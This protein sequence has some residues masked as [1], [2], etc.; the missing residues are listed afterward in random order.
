MSL[1]RFD[2]SSIPPQANINEA[3]LRIYPYE[4]DAAVEMTVE[5]YRLLRPWVDTEANWEKASIEEVWGMPGANGPG[6]D[7]ET[8]PVV[9]Q[10]V[11]LL[12]IWYEF[13]ISDLVRGWVNSP[14]TNYGLLLRG[15]GS[16]SVAYNFAS[17]NYPSIST[18]PQL[19]IDY[20]AP[21]ATFTPLPKTPTPTP[22]QTLTPSAAPTPIHTATPSPAPIISPTPT[23]IVGPTPTATS[24]MDYIADMERRVGIVQELLARIIDIFRRL[25]QFER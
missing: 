1:I 19:V 14:Q 25:S 23:P 2:L 12:K 17:A 6:A 4:R 11:S 9:T 15:L 13:D 3:V 16:A 20:T 5:V 8:T 7:R 10:T 22:T 21:E 18:R 24:I